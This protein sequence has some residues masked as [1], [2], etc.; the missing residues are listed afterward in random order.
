MKTS[1]DNSNKDP[2]K[3][4]CLVVAGSVDVGKSS[5]I[6]VLTSG[7]LDDGK[8]L[9]RSV[10][11]RHPHE[12]KQGKTSDIS[13]RTLSLNNK[14]V[15]LVD[16]CGHEKYLKTTLYGITGLFPDYGILIVAAGRGMI[17]MSKE[18]LGIFLHLKIPFIILLTRVDITPQNIY[19]RET[20]NIT[21]LL[22]K[23][24]KK[25][26]YIN[27][28]S[29]IELLPNELMEKEREAIDSLDKITKELKVNPFLVPIL[30]I[31]N[32]TGY[33]I[34]VA[35][36]LLSKLECRI[37]MW[38]PIKGSIF[39]IDSK[40]T[41]NGI[42]LVVSGLLRGVSVPVNSELLIGPF[43]NLGEFKRIKVWSIHNNN[44]Q[45]LNVLDQRNRGCFAIKVI[46]KKDEIG[47]LSIR[48]G[49]V[50]I[51][52]EVD[53]AVCYE[54]IATIEILNHSTAISPHYIATIHCGSIRQ[55][56][57]ISFESTPDNPTLKLGD[58][59]EVSFRFFSH[60]E[61]MEVGSTFFFREGTTRGV[62]IVNKLILVKDDPNPGPMPQNK[63]RKK[64]MVR[65]KKKKNVS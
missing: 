16:L 26:K 35:K 34:N 43:G 15:T 24:K 62:G 38:Q 19:E 55:S 17:K 30:S 12:I 63:K 56:A 47:P 10:V 13:T 51:S 28:L 1:T 3:E 41:V 31:S 18:H 59:R 36:S 5:F 45:V 40:F 27:S 37:D 53:Q 65:K 20:Y 50:I 49:L 9:A 44:R 58:K 6:G 60:P 39:Y 7:I 22:K 64:K 14:N 25:P 4:V 46:D 61:F 57:K 52:K 11:A 29:D 48:K 42:G 21:K 23:Y 32:K 33:Y 54:F 2:T 8:G